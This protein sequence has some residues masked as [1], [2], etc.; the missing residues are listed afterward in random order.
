MGK[1]PALKKGSAL[2]KGKALKK[3]QPMKGKQKKKVNGKDPEEK[4]RKQE[5][6]ET[7]TSNKVPPGIWKKP[8]AGPGVPQTGGAAMSLEEKMELFAKKGNQTVSQFLDGLS[9]NQ[10]EAL[11]QRFASARSGL[12]DK[13]QEQ[14]WN[15][16]CEGKGSD[17]NKKLLLV[18]FLKSRGNLKKSDLYQKELLALVKSSGILAAL[19][20]AQAGV[21]KN[22]LLFLCEAKR[23]R[24]SGSHWP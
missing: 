20:W 4:E 11:W 10:R 1:K 16:H 18:A 21:N 23:K 14:L 3:G 9:K 6:A 12:K 17:E 19:S 7:R 2:D 13:E 8:S 22:G 5:T 15:A 24:K